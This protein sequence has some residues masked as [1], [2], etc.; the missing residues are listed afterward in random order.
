MGR[1]TFLD[2]EQRPAKPRSDGITAVIDGGLPVEDVDAVLATNAGFIDLWKLGWGSSYLDP[3]LAAKL[4]VLRRHGVAP[5]PG[6]TLL[7]IAAL[8]DRVDAFLEWALECGF[9]FLEV[10]DGLDLLGAER[11]AALIRRVGSCVPVIAE[12]GTKD[13]Q[14]ALTAGAWVELALADLDA[15]ATW[16]ITEGRESGTVGIYG[17][18]GRVRTDVV[19]AL[20][21]RVGTERLMF[22]APRKDQQAWFVNHVGSQVNLSNVAPRDAMGLEALRLGLRADT[23]ASALL[24]Q[25]PVRS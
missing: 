23:T 17:P 3:R 20:V 22:E 19:E 12:V 21:E 24:R 6:G 18:D 2:L 7:E 14:P 4:A 11:K 5:C 13:P 9:P 8:Q 10:S 16:V 25:I 1:P 15:G